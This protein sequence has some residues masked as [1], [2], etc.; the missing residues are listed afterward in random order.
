MRRV[1][2]ALRR[3][4]RGVRAGQG[5]LEDR[6]HEAESRLQGTPGLLLQALRPPDPS[7][8]RPA[9]ARITP[10]GAALPFGRLCGAHSDTARVFVCSVC[11]HPV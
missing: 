1:N 10:L 2:R 11:A 5:V 6:T 7:P 9:P 8:P 3:G 4:N